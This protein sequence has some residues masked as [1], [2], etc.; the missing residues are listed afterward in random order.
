MRGARL[1]RTSAVDLGAFPG[2]SPLAPYPRRDEDAS[3]KDVFV[4]KLQSTR[5]KTVEA[6]RPEVGSVKLRE[7]VGVDLLGIAI[8]RL[9]KLVS[10]PEQLDAPVG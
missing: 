7:P 4:E 10:R 3:S 6:V 9:G 5:V 8:G 2:D 1:L